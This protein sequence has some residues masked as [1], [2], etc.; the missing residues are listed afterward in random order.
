M[1]E[2]TVQEDGLECCV[3]DQIASREIY[4][5]HPLNL[6]VLPYPGVK[7][8]KEWKQSKCNGTAILVCMWYNAFQSVLTRLQKWSMIGG[9]AKRSWKYPRRFNLTMNGCTTSLGIFV[10]NCTSQMVG[11]KDWPLT[12]ICFVFNPNTETL[13]QKYF[14]FMVSLLAQGGLLIHCRSGWDRTPLWISLLRFTA[15]F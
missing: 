14:S 2:V 10:C 13:T 9:S 11:R 7:L 3:A 12:F 6:C 8:F 4:C 15:Y 1:T 5:S